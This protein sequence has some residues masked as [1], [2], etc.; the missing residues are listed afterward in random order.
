MPQQSSL[1]LEQSVELMVIRKIILAMTY[2]LTFKRLTLG[3]PPLPRDS[4]QYEGT[5][6][7][8]A[9]EVGPPPGGS[10]NSRPRGSQS[11]LNFFCDKSAMPKRLELDLGPGEFDLHF[12]QAML[13][14]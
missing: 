13:G 11:F 14:E 5:F 6:R 8:G 9:W 10:Q 2:S 4:R 1:L 3:R 7:G 12:F